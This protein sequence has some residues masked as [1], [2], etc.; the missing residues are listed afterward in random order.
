MEAE[1]D[2]EILGNEVDYR[3]SSHF[4][5]WVLTED[6]IKSKSDK[7]YL[8]AFE[9]MKQI[10]GS[11]HKSFNSDSEHIVI[12]NFVKNIINIVNEFSLSSS[13]KLTVLTIFRR[14]CLKKLIIDFDV[15]FIIYTSFFLGFKICE[16]PM[17]LD[18][19]P[20][21]FPYLKD[22]NSDFKITKKT[23]GIFDTR[24]CS[25]QIQVIFT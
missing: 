17:N 13:L 18:R 14:F 19:L 8:M 6:Q 5:K 20:S 15:Y 21:I 25:L 23:E 7:K 22:D 3:N 12:N 24:I 10:Y 2:A 16:I 1:K 4:K 9:I 11:I